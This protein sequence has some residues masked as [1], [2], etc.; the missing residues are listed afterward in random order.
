MYENKRNE[1]KWQCV[2]L[3]YSNNMSFYMTLSIS[4]PSLC[5]NNTLKSTGQCT[6]WV[7]LSTKQFSISE[8]GDLKNT[9]FKRLEWMHVNGVVTDTRSR[10]EI[11]AISHPFLKLTFWCEGRGEETAMVLLEDAFCCYIPTAPPNWKEAMTKVLAIICRWW[12]LRI[13]DEISRETKNKY[14]ETTDGDP[15]QFEPAPRK[16]L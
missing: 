11:G 2:N 4:G 14:R 15:C 9:V 1:G 8:W 5:S 12:K 13:Y 16:N 10:I 6:A 3:S 7:S